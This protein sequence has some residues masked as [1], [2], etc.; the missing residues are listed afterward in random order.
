MPLTARLI[1]SALAACLA[2]GAA[3]QSPAA[4]T[5][6]AIVA[7]HVKD[8]RQPIYGFGGSQTY[9]G[10]NLASFPGR[11]A[12]YRALFQD[13]KIDIFRLRNYNGYPGQQAKFEQVTREFASGALKWGGDPKTRGGKAPVRLMF[14]SWS[15]P[16]ALKSNGLAS[17]RSDGTDQGQANATLKQDASGQFVYGP[18]ADWWLDS[19]KTFKTLTNV[20]PDY[21][22]LQNELE[23]PAT[24]E[25]CL[26][27]PVEGANPKGDKIAGYDRALAAVS[28]RLMGALGASAPKIVGPETFSLKTSTGNPNH[29]LNYINPEGAT[30]KAELSR[31]FGVSFHIYGAGAAGGEGGP[32]PARFKTGLNQVREAYRADG[33]DKPLFQTEFLEGDSLTSVAGIISDTFTEGDVSAYLV[34]IA[35]RSV[36]QPGGYALV[37]YNPDDGSVERRERFYAVKAFSEFVGEG[38]HRVAADCGDPGLKFSAYVGPHAGDLVTVLVNPTGQPH[39]V[40]LAPD[41]DAYRDAATAVYRSSEGE[42]GEHWHELGA[43]PSGNVV[44]LTPRSVVTVRFT[45]PGSRP[46]P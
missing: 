4:Q 42:V 28:D 35:A 37:Y 20:Y 41:G 18:Y 14:T 13:L 40:T 19:L 8:V 32:D 23:F 36:K 34:W 31:L 38:W 25:G 9:A 17:G 1:V 15:P 24:Y 16:P 30:G 3:A 21:I 44:T 10:D 22:A 2:A 12:V 27:L 46:L 39:R 7:I 45:R 29:V 5:P 33:A 43:L 6:P 11:D 26:F